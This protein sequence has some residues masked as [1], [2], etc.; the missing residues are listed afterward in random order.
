MLRGVSGGRQEIKFANTC[1][2]R[3]T[4]PI[5]SKREDDLIVIQNVQFKY[6]QDLRHFCLL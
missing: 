5:L 4:L 2:T 6:R 1:N 3:L